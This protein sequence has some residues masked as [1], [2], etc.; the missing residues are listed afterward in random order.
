[1]LSNLPVELQNHIF[2]YLL[3]SVHSFE[4]IK[5]NLDKYQLYN[6]NYNYRYKIAYYNNE[7]LFCK[8]YLLS[9]IE[10]KNGNH[11]YYLTKE[12]VTLECDNCFKKSKYMFCQS[13]IPKSLFV[14]S[15]FTVPYSNCS[16]N[17]NSDICVSVMYS[18]HYIGNEKTQSNTHLSFSSGFQN[19][20]VLYS[21]G[22]TI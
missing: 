20:L 9:R 2:E 1:M 18:S 13:P 5:V 17:C 11:R 14:T 19:I 4:F 16:R 10:K 3:G 22:S 21:L 6:E 15:K 12:L 8:N 7:R